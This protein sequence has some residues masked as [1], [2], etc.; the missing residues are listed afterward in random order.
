MAFKKGLNVQKYQ[1]CLP[2]IWL[3]SEK[4]IEL[5]LFKTWRFDFLRLIGKSGEESSPHTACRAY[6]SGQT[7]LNHGLVLVLHFGEEGAFFRLGLSNDRIAQIVFQFWTFDLN[8]E[9]ND[10]GILK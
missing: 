7:V 2:K 9:G 3:C 1:L 8:L 5:F 10:F 6:R 4:N